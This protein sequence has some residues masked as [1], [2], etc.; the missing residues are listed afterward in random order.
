MRGRD[1]EVNGLLN[2]VRRRLQERAR[3][4]SAD[5]TDNDVQ[6]SEPIARLGHKTRRLPQV[7][8]VSHHHTGTTPRRFYGLGSRLKLPR[9]ARGDNYVSAGLSQRDRRRR[10][11][12]A[13]RTSDDRHLAI[14]PELI[15][16]HHPTT[17]LTGRPLSAITSPGTAAA[18]AYLRRLQL[19]PIAG[20][21][22][23][24]TCQDPVRS[25]QEHRA[26]PPTTPQDFPRT[27]CGTAD[28][29]ALSHFSVVTACQTM[30][31]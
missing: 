16:Q 9:R 21:L 10:A 5:I 7:S 22:A 18:A 4:C 24:N 31:R 2:V 13:S 29:T 27:P 23:C 17:S 20:R 19:W 1:I 8:Q 3:R 25:R 26:L 30:S 11:D 14:H 15:R 6:P 28:L 12:P